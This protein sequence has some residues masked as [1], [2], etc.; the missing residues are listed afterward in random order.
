M[1][2]NDEDFSTRVANLD[3][4]THYFV[5]CL[6]G[7]RS[8]SAIKQMQANG[9]THLTE[10]KGGMM[11]WRKAGLPVVEMES[12]SDKISRENYEHLISG[13]LVLIDFYAP[14]CGP[15]RKMEPHLEELQKKYEGRVKL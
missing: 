2:F 7:G 12:V 3:K 15:C 10:L 11:A 6:A 9:I 4:N 13:Q 5:Y 14:W 1:D 8:T